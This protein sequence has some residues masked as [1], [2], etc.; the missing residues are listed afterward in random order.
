M[1]DGIYSDRESWIQKV[2][3]HSNQLFELL[4]VPITETAYNFLR[5]KKSNIQAYV[6]LR[7]DRPRVILSFPSQIKDP[8][9]V[10]FTLSVYVSLQH[11]SV[12]R[13]EKG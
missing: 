7:E 6:Y 1:S 3:L 12:E 9:E 4:T 11:E 8:I 10:D 13:D 5:G 2:R